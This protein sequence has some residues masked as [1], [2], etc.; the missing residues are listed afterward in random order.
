MTSIS[1]T[2]VVN[3]PGGLVELGYGEFSYAGNVTATSGS[4]LAVMSPL[5]VICDGSPI[6]IDAYI[7][8]IR[9]ALTA[10]AFII[11]ELYEDGLLINSQW[12]L[13][14]TPASGDRFSP[15]SCHLRRT[16]S[17][18]AHTY[19][20]KT[21]VSGGTGY[22][23]S[24][25]FGR[26]ASFLRVSKIIQASQLIVQTPNAP[27]VTS[28]PSN[29]IDGQEVRYLA[30]N[31]NGIIW[32]LRYR[33]GSSSA[34]KWEFIGGHPLLAYDSTQYNTTNTTLTR[35]GSS[36]IT[37]PL[38]G[39]Y[40]FDGSCGF[41]V[42]GTGAAQ[43]VYSHLTINGTAIGSSKT[44]LMASALSNAGVGQDSAF[45]R[46]RQDDLSA[47]SNIYMMYASGASGL[48]VY[49]RFIRYSATPIRVSA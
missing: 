44:Y 41:V 2:N 3:A 18:G 24:G 32:N 46:V 9:P 10:G 15:A 20:V 40:S 48:T 25:D 19:Q 21:Y 33:A 27:L 7:A 35:P 43:Y 11:V 17:A 16:P 45:T 5:T 30:D 39:D 37:L 29:A 38:A 8:G 12:A 28:L 47:G 13:V 36:Q 4:P 31:T 22:I 14:I 1:D 6:L 34:H 42:S 49:I 23:S 26:S